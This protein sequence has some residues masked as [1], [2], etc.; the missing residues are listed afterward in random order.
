M[1]NDK[2]IEVTGIIKEKVEKGSAVLK[3]NDTPIA[4]VFET[5]ND[6]YV[7]INIFVHQ[8]EY[9]ELVRNFEGHAEVYYFEGKQLFFSGTKYVN[10]FLIDDED[11][12]ETLE[13]FINRQITITI[14]I[15]ESNKKIKEKT[16]PPSYF[17]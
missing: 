11:V 6:Q 16:L 1:V 12:I 10:D 2:S 14:D 8:S 9:K 3:I 15:M 7:S 5:L 13:E 4:K 17:V